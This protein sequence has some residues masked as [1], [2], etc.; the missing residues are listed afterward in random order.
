MKISMR[1]YFF[2]I[3]IAVILG[4]GTEQVPI[5]LGQKNTAD[6][7]NCS[8]K[9][10]KGYICMD[11]HCTVDSVS[12]NNSNSDVP[13][14]N[15][16]NTTDITSVTSANIAS[17][18]NL[19]CI[20][21]GDS[22]PPKPSDYLCM[23]YPT[24]C[25]DKGVC[26]LCLKP[27]IGESFK[28]CDTSKILH[29][30]SKEVSCTDS[31]DNDCD[32]LVDCQDS[33]CFSQTFCVCEGVNLPSESNKVLFVAWTT[34]YKQAYSKIE[35]D[36][37]TTD[38]QVISVIK[39]TQEPERGFS[40]GD[41]QKAL[42]ENDIHIIFFYSVWYDQGS[43]STYSAPLDDQALIDFYK[44]NPYQEIIID[45]R[46][47][48]D[49]PPYNDRVWM[50]MPGA[51]MADTNSQPLIQNYY[52]NLKKS[53]GGMV[54]L[55]DDQRFVSGLN[56]VF[57]G[58]GIKPIGGQVYSE[59]LPFDNLNPLMSSPNLIAALNNQTSTGEV[60]FNIQ[61]NGRVLYTAAWHS[62]DQNRPAIA[63]TISG[64]IGF[65]AAITSP[66]AQTTYPPGESITFSAGVIGGTAPYT[67]EW[68]DES[69]SIFGN[70]ESVQNAALS[71]GAHYIQVKVTDS[72]GLV[73]TSRVLIG[74]G[75]TI[76]AL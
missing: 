17:G 47:L 51:G 38:A 50:N 4:C 12:Q 20:D 26:A 63:T 25:G 59:P 6:K 19:F 41:V 57:N 33:D 31:L 60:P 70:Q 18:M 62:G 10:A 53:G 76:S 8:L 55:T 13:N 1:H 72:K 27:C 75:C 5:E 52:Y 21:S 54:F 42:Q 16:N 37:K 65:R 3:C 61:P 24:P 71:S 14:D 56:R 67:Y 39:S 68:S 23:G 48:G 15:S 66:K 45:A 34:D 32:G 29:Y 58:I 69:N 43:P 40:D 46:I 35:A 7:G 44:K 74:I 49:I 22:F 36:L 28:E 2:L 30:E 64:G 73:S 9:C 11:G